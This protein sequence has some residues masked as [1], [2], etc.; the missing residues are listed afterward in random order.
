MHKNQNIFGETLKECSCQPVTGFFRN[1]KCS[2]SEDDVG[3][4]TVCVRITKEFLQF[5]TNQGNDLSTP[6]PEFGFQGLCE[7]DKWCL[8]AERWLEAY[9]AGCAPEVFLES[10]H[11]HSLTVI[12]KEHLEEKAISAKVIPMFQEQNPPHPSS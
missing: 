5:S 8:C 1:G 12:P 10:T 9:R 6:R 7:G 3:M 11:L 2:T 4:H